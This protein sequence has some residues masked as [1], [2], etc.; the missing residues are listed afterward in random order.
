MSHATPEDN[1]FTKW[2]VSQLTIAGYEVWSDVTK[3]L[4]GERFWN[5]IEDAITV[6]AF[7]FLFVSTLHANK[8]SGTLQELQLAQKAQ[9]K[10]RLKDFVISTQN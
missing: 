6:K 1:E 5:N 8:K 7:R 4:G 2:L 9:S 10:Y 3:L